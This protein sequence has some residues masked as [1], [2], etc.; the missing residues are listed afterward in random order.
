[1]PSGAYGNTAALAQAISR[2]ITKAGVPPTMTVQHS[3]SSRQ[4]EKLFQV[5]VCSHEGLVLASMPAGSLQSWTAAH[6]AGVGVE[7]LNLESEELDDIV[8]ALKRCKGFVIGSPTLGGHMPTQVCAVPAA[9][10]P[11]CPACQ[12]L[13]ATCCT[14]R[15]EPHRTACAAYDMPG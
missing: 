7:T 1:M 4:S 15:C 8:A 2:G 9:A 13:S 10:V 6:C 5:W 3:T 11:A 14:L 12:H